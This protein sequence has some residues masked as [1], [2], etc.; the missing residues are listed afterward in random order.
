MTA[1]RIAAAVVAGIALGIGLIAFAHDG[2]DK[3]SGQESAA[4]T[5]VTP[6]LNVQSVEAS[7]AHYTTVLGFKKD[8]D[9]PAEAEDKTFASI[10]NGG[11]NVFLAEKGQG[12]RPVWIYYSVNNVDELHE[13]YAR[14]GADV[15]QKPVDQSW[16][17]REML[18]ADID[19]HILRIGGPGKEGH[20]EGGDEHGEG[21]KKH[22][23]GGEDNDK[24]EGRH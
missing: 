14:A 2:R 9:W 17:A 6:I 1:P 24:E 23:E 10:S 4:F 19:G 21:K 7:I 3:D 12:S 13:K 8:W 16:G 22:D 5:A 15:R 18:V 11:V 20:D